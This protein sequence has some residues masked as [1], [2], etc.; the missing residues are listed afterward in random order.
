MI[1]KELLAHKKVIV[2]TATDGKEAVE[3][4]LKYSKKRGAAYDLILMDLQMP[5]MDGFEASAEIQKLIKAGEVKETPIVAL[6]ANNSDKDLEKCNK[7][8]MKEHI[9]KPLM[10]QSLQALLEKYLPKEKL[11]YLK[12]L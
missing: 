6:S 7:V 10:D 11:N 8:G 5:V 1:A 3:Q 2:H 9:L 4:V 12:Q